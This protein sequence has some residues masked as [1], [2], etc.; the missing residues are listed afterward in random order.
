MYL[1][2]ADIVNR[3]ECKAIENAIICTICDGVVV[4]PLQCVVCENLFCRSCIE[5]WEKR[6][7]SCPF[8]CQNFK[9]KENKMMNNILKNVKF[10]CSNGCDMIIPYDEIKEHYNGKCPKIDYKPKYQK[11]LE[12]FENLKIQKEKLSKGIDVKQ[13]EE[14]KKENIN[15]KINPQIKVKLHHHPLIRL[16]TKRA[17]WF[18]DNCRHNYYRD[19]KSYYCSLCDYDLCETC[20]R[21]Q[22]NFNVPKIPSHRPKMKGERCGNQ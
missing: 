2:K 18:C 5:Q 4:D 14:M 9:L 3:E 7:K 21:L 17:G 10:K 11:A 15:A 19:E 12:E 13:L 16:V 6:S 8:K 1:D 22:F 20:K